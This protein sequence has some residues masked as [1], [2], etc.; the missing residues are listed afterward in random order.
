[1]W[2]ERTD[3]RQREVVVRRR[4][5]VLRSFLNNYPRGDD[6][7]RVLTTSLIVDAIITKNT[8]S[9]CTVIPV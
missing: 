7:E 9:Y 2:K 1:M 8:T 3:D 6:D 4:Q 5:S